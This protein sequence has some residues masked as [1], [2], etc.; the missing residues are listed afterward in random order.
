VP[1][2]VFVLLEALLE[3]DPARPF[4]NPTELSK[5]IPAII[6]AIDR[7]RRI[8]RQ[9]LQKTSS[10]VSHVGS[11]KPPVRPPPKKISIARLPVTGSDIFGRD[12]DIA[13]LDRAW[14]NRD[15]NVVTFTAF[16]E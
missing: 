6:D 3:K 11:R 2:P 5:A 10:A 1:E 12:E 8:T 16:W 14:T 15:V 7:G 9:N 13:F 4:Q